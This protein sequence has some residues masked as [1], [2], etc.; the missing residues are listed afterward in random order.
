MK[1]IGGYLARKKGGYH[2]TFTSDAKEKSATIWQKNFTHPFIREL[3][4]GILPEEKF[5]Y[6]LLQDRY[7]LRQ[8]QALYRQIAEKTEHAKIRVFFE[9]GGKRLVA[10]EQAIRNTLFQEMGISNNEIKQ[11][12]MAE[13]PY[14]YVSHMYR[15][16]IYSPTVAFASLLPCAL[17]YQEIGLTLNQTGSPH[18]YYQTW[19]DTCITEESMAIVSEFQQ[20]L[21]E[22]Y[23]QAS[24]AEQQ[25]MLEAFHIS[26]YMEYAF[27]EM[28]YQRKMWGE[29][30]Y[31]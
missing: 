19:I 21:N 12:P 15:Q 18:P 4:Q 25:Q 11:V 16:L 24:T 8:L 10:G 30:T 2:M 22:C 3:H 27:W 13:V 14:H 17:L 26:T 7:Y 31:A 6:Y 20:L 1:P 5:R 9:Q 29:D 23:E 28:A